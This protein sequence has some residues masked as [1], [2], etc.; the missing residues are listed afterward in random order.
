M[1][2]SKEHICF[3]FRDALLDTI[4]AKGSTRAAACLTPGAAD[5]VAVLSYRGPPTVADYGFTVRPSGGASSP[6]RYG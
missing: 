2:Q 3:V 1:T 5:S 6:R 4:D